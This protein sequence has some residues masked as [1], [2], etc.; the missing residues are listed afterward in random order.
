MNKTPKGTA[1]GLSL[2]EL[3]ATVAIIAV[4]GVAS[5]PPMHQWVAR[6]RIEAAAND[7]MHDLHAARRQA[8]AHSL[9]AV[10]CP[11]SNGTQCTTNASF[12]SG[13]LSFINADADSPPQVDIGETI[14]SV[15][16]G[17]PRV[18]ILSNRRQFQF[19]GR[20]RR[21]TNGS[22]TLCDRSASTPPQTLTVSYTG[23][24]RRNRID[25][26]GVCP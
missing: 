15:N 14:L 8:I 18:A 20:A 9:P 19:N 26:A 1:S 7:L 17:D 11:T 24:V 13:W 4:L 6:Q 21:A 10:V 22:I 16:T 2:V 23:R 12:G 25:S 5:I 3:L